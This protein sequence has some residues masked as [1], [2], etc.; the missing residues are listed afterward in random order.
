M[1]LSNYKKDDK[2]R[3]TLMINN[4]KGWIYID[5][6]GRVNGRWNVLDAFGVSFA[7]LLMLGVMLV[8]S[9][10]YRTS[11]QMIKGETDLEYTV[12]LR[13]VKTSQPDLIKEGNKIA[14]SIRNQPRGD[15]SVVSVRVAPRK[16]IAPNALGGFQLIDDPEDPNG[17]DV[18]VRL[19][20]HAQITGD[21]Y[22]A[23]GIKIKVGL[24]IE[25]EG[26]D[27]RLP[28]VIFDIAAN[29]DNNSTVPA[30]AK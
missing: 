12:Y 9:G 7:V 20:D 10:L 6:F 8:Q 13:N 30:D 11:G 4:K 16:K 18:W 2:E 15:V 27:F 14:L 23:N 17:F 24:P 26:F 21:G 25:V 1:A 29:T 5:A 28:G 22:V 19:K 3:A